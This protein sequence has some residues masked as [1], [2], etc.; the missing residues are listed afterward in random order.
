MSDATISVKISTDGNPVKEGNP[1]TWA[2]EVTLFH[3]GQVRTLS[4]VVGQDEDDPR[5]KTVLLHAFVE[6][7]KAIESFGVALDELQDRMLP[8]TRE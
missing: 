7:R 6:A 4:M 1:T 2:A 8:D 3:R 5:G